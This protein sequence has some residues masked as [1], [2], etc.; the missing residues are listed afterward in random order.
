MSGTHA[1]PGYFSRNSFF[2][3]S[4]REFSKTPIEAQMRSIVERED[5][6]PRGE[7]SPLRAGIGKGTNSFVPMKAAPD[8]R[9]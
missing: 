9:L 7:G 2:G 3:K 6:I 8:L 1:L 4:V 5:G